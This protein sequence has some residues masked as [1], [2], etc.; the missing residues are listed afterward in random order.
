M[1]S[2]GPFG[3]PKHAYNYRHIPNPLRG[4][5]HRALHRMHRHRGLGKWRR[6]FEGRCRSSEIYGQK[7][8]PVLKDEGDLNVLILV[9]KKASCPA[10]NVFTT[11]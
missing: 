7:N 10:L 8:A 3:F 4:Q 11:E 9:K 2:A 6:R 1:Q 5:S